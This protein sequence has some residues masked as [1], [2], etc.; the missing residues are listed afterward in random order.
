[1]K[2]QSLPRVILSIAM[3]ASISSAAQSQTWVCDVREAV[4]FGNDQGYRLL[5]FPTNRSYIIRAPVSPSDLTMEFQRN[6]GVFSDTSGDVVPASFQVI[7]TQMVTLCLM[8]TFPET[9]PMGRSTR[10]TC[11]SA[12]MSSDKFVFNLNTGR[13]TQLY[14]GFESETRSASWVEVGECRRTM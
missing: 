10:I 3:C 8:I 4:G 6:H 2:L 7:G 5:N 12:G 13:F 1:M 14:S 11:D 9:S